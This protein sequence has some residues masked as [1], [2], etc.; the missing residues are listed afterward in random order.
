MKNLGKIILLLLITNIVVFASVRASVDAK[1]VEIGEMVTYSLQISGKDITRPIINSLCGVDVISTGS[2]TSIEMINGSISRN[3]VLSYKFIPQKSCVIEPIEVDIDGSMQ[4]SNKVEVNVTKIMPNKDADF[5]LIL[6]SSKKE[7]YVGEAFEVNLLLK[8]KK[9]AQ[10]VDSKFMPPKLKGIWIKSESQPTRSEDGQYSITK[11]T[12]KMAAQRVGQLKITK[13]QMRIASRSHIRD[14]WGSWIPKIKW[15]TYFSNELN[16][17]VKEL[18][19][20]VTLV[21][22]FSITASVDKTE[23]NLNEAINLSVEVQGNGNLEDI[24]SFKPY[25]DGVNIFDEKIV[26]KGDVLT[27]GIVFVGENDFVIKPLTLTFFNPITKNIQTISTQVIN[28]KVKNP[29]VKEKLTIKKEEIKQKEKVVETQKESVSEYLIILIFVLGMA[30]GVLIMFLKSY[31]VKPKKQTVSIKEPK[32]LLMKLLPFKNNE[33]VKNMMD[34]LEKNIYEDA[35]IEIDKKL[36]KELI[37]KY[38]IS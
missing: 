28:I 21:G 25:I 29:K 36:L 24:K 38:D 19:K 16:I 5:I 31:K 7:V 3:N 13:A 10:A 11:I 1:N 34:V 32:K 37:V 2:Q 23:I 18:P 14:T 30:S 15:K 26:I 9:D 35:K 4:K 22:D 6:Q 27:Q 8:Q 20:G 12:Y 33:D 17:D